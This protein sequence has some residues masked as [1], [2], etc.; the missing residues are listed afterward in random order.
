MG[1]NYE[2]LN[3][4]RALQQEA[5]MHACARGLYEEFGGDLRE[6]AVR[7]INRMQTEVDEALDAALNLKGG[8]TTDLGKE[9]ADVVLVAFSAAQQLGIDLAS[10]I[11]DKNQFNRHRWYEGKEDHLA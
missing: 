4:M 1:R 11:E 9:L 3:A 5:H 10:S 2:R 7:L 8:Y 6:Q